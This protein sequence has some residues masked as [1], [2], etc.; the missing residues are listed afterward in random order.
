M[1]E[2][3]KQIIAAAFDAE[4]ADQFCEGTI[5]AALKLCEQN[6]GLFLFPEENPDSLLL[7]FHYWPQYH[8][9]VEE[10]D[11]STL[12][13]LALDN[14]PILHIV[15]MVE[16]RNGFRVLRKVIEKFNPWG[17]TAHRWDRRRKEWH[18]VTLKNPE[19]R[20]FQLGPSQFP[21]EIHRRRR[22]RHTQQRL[23]FVLTAGRQ[24]RGPGKDGN[25]AAGSHAANQRQSRECPSNPE[26]MATALRVS[27]DGRPG[28]Q[29]NKFRL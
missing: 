4:L 23:H 1:I 5:D 27:C 9:A 7:Y 19:R 25:A 28:E 26:C 12:E 20:A 16:P 10:M 11:Y 29:R 15:A 21:F 17:L 8:K 22:T 3:A 2:R 6:G 24:R 14:G 18:F 13:E